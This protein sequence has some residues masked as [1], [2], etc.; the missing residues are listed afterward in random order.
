[1]TTQENKVHKMCWRE[2]RGGAQQNEEIVRRKVFGPVTLATQFDDVE[3]S[4]RAHMLQNSD[5][6]SITFNRQHIALRSSSDN[7]R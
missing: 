6:L 4:V 3:P 5:T 2:T 7:A 1:M